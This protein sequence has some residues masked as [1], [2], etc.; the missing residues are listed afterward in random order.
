MQPGRKVYAQAQAVDTQFGLVVS[1]YHFGGQTLRA[2]VRPVALFVRGGAGWFHRCLGRRFA[3]GGRH[4]G[5][6]DR[7]HGVLVGRALGGAGRT[8]SNGV[9]SDRQDRLLQCLVGQPRPAPAWSGSRTGGSK[10]L[11]HDQTLQTRVFNGM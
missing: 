2:A 4:P 5:L 7:G 8:A 11:E 9:V 1:E 10:F 6:A 3:L